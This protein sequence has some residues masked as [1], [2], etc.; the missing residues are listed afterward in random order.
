[1]RIREGEFELDS[2]F[3]LSPVPG[4][5]DVF[6]LTLAA[7]G[8]GRNNDYLVALESILR[9]VTHVAGTIHEV[10]VDSRDVRRGEPSDALVPLDYPIAMSTVIDHDALRLRITSAVV[11]I[12]Q[13]DG[14][15]GGN[16]TKRLVVVIESTRSIEELRNAFQL[17]NSTDEIWHQ[18]SELP[19]PL[20]EGRGT[21]VLV[22]RRER[23]PAA[24]RAC[25]QAHGTA[26][27]VCSMNFGHAYGPLGDGFI[28]VHH[29]YPISTSPVDGR[30]VDG[31]DD[32]RPVCPNCHAM[33][34]R[35]GA[36]DGAP[37]A[38]EQ[39]REVWEDRHRAASPSR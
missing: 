23:N 5:P 16:S 28:E 34:H 39:L 6:A 38:I 14:A 35:G 18:P 29:L 9:T 15:R 8:G 22:D 37:L 33:L 36:A 25:I 24:R 13:R 2:E 32:L 26:C 3:E 20:E 30:P 10:R 4:R 21:T 1:M 11:H 7:R 12:G 19:K 31:V 17:P 27:A